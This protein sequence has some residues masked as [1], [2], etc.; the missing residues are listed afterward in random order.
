MA[1]ARAARLVSAGA[2][3]AYDAWVDPARWA[4][5]VD[6]FREVER[7][8]PNWPDPG[9]EVAWRSVPDG[10]G[11]VHE[12]VEVARRGECFETAVSD[13]SLTGSQTVSLEPAPA[14]GSRERTLVTV[15]LDYRLA[16]GGP[17]RALTD[18]LFIRRALGD[19][20]SR[21]L[22]RFA[23]EIDQRR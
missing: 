23:A 16:Q 7:L 12:R 9:A 11:T 18:V 2:A 6:G 5:F 17:L 14:E 19:S 10:R 3:R 1:R 20:L 15:T 13:P 4:A 8:D 22:A 21:T